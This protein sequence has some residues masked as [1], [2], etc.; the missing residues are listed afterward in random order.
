MCMVVCLLAG[1]PSRCLSLLLD[2]ISEGTAAQLLSTNRQL[3]YYQPVWY[4]R[5]QRTGHLKSSSSTC[6]ELL[7]SSL[8]DARQNTHTSTRCIDSG[9]E[10][11]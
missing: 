4:V 2:P 9:P 5:A 8:H 7:L 10:A 1:R 11:P 3:G 6:L